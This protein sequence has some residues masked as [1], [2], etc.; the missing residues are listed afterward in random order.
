MHEVG[1]VQRALALSSAG[2]NCCQIYRALGVPR[3]TISDWTR[4]KIPGTTERR[5]PDLAVESLAAQNAP[6]YAYLLGLYL[7]DGHIARMQRTYCLRIS[8]DSA[9]PKIIDSAAA[10]VDELFPDGRVG[11]YRHARANLVIVSSYSRHWPRL[12]P[13]HGPGAK[14]LRKIEL[15]PWQR[16]LTGAHP[17]QF[18]RGLIHADGCRYVANQ[19]SRRRRYGY[20]RYGFSNTSRDIL[21]L[22]C[23]HL[24]ALGVHWTLATPERVQIAK[25]E[26]VARLDEF[27]GPKR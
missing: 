26:A 19:R 20:P 7:G 11:K 13:Q 9:Y 15:R 4:G 22:F 21:A 23:E 6:A 17:Q 18:I 27:V 16:R 10:A 5:Y 2:L 25:R 14:H 3:R 24:D 1:T 8:L 12:L